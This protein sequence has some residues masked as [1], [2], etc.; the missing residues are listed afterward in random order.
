M[1]WGYPYFWKHPY[2]SLLPPSVFWTTTKHR[3]DRGW[4][5]RN[6]RQP[7]GD[8]LES[9]RE[10]NGGRW[11]FLRPWKLLEMMREDTSSFFFF[12]FLGG[13]GV[14]TLFESQEVNLRK[15]TTIKEL[16]TRRF[17]RSSPRASHR[18]VESWRLFS[19]KTISRFKSHQVRTEKP[20]NHGIIGNL[21][22]IPPPP[23][24]RNKA[25][26]RDS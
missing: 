7:R 10:R 9:C 26:L 16:W 18:L 15:K 19:P 8:Y 3:H 25:L 1:I 17:C 5:L 12:F 11:M 20:S 22:L 14:Y 6:T 2:V 21:R 24:Q 13:G 4:Q 23:P